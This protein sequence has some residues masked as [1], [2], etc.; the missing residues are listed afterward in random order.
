VAKSLHDLP[1]VLTDLEQ[2]FVFR[3]GGKTGLEEAKRAE[4]INTLAFESALGA[5]GQLVSYELSSDEDVEFVK[6][7][8]PVQLTYAEKEIQGQGRTHHPEGFSSPIGR[9]KNLPDKLPAHVS[10]EDLARL[11]VTV[12]KR[13]KLEM[14]S[15][16]I[17]SGDVKNILRKDGK[18]LLITWQHAT[19]RRGEKIYFEPSWGTFDQIIGEKVVSVFCGPADRSA[20]GDYYVGEAQT[21]PGRSDHFTAKEKKRFA[22]YD[23]LRGLRQG[24]AAPNDVATLERLSHEVMTDHSDHWLLALEILEVARQKYHLEPLQSP[25]LKNLQ[26]SCTNLAQSRSSPSASLIERGLETSAI[27]D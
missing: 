20:F 7:S 23:A 14:N 3:C 21:S 18:L 13:S 19:V 11:G 6:F 27:L 10:D 5:S 9:F 8:G 16:F 4:T 24:K 15:G 2:T 1:E 26:I 25:W 17:I 22:I 12:G